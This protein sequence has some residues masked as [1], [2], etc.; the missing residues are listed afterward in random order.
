MEVPKA[1]TAVLEIVAVRRNHAAA[2][3][4]FVSRDR[5]ANMP[6]REPDLDMEHEAPSSQHCG[7]Q[8]MQTAPSERKR[9]A[10]INV[11]G[12]HNGHDVNGNPSLPCPIS[13][14]IDTVSEADAENL[15]RERLGW[16]RIMS[17]GGD[18]SDRP[19][20]DMQPEEE[21][22]LRESLG[23]TRIMEGSASTPHACPEKLQS[24]GPS[25]PPK[26]PLR[27]PAHSKSTPPRGSC[28]AA[29]SQRLQVLKRQKEAPCVEGQEAVPRDEH[30]GWQDAKRDV[31]EAL[32]KRLAGEPGEGEAP[33]S[34]GAQEELDSSRMDDACA[35]QARL[36]CGMD[37]VITEVRLMSVAKEPRVAGIAP[38][39]KVASQGPLQ[40][41]GEN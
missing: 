28:I 34:V 24:I 31:S 7:A 14:S 11:A 23:W 3:R 26:G 21:E 33:A 5:L 8:D 17:P 36:T 13:G 22:H 10:L 20:I 2:S 38:A 41:S 29:I 25:P 1:S 39:L 35:T 37:E 18:I 12:M 9:Q 15:L 16:V 32:V 40:V 27:S 30:P 19:Q 4:G 6:S